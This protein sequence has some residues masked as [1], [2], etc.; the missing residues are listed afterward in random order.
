MEVFVDGVDGR[1]PVT[2]I[3]WLR[4]G[5]ESGFSEIVPVVAQTV[6]GARSD[7]MLTVQAIPQRR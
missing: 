5:G 4:E 6:S 2:S 3:E 1:K 7:A